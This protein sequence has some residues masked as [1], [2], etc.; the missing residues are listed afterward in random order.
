M[1]IKKKLTG[2]T[3]LEIMITII[4]TSMIMMALYGVLVSA[5]QAHELISEV[6]H[7]MDVG[8]LIMA[9]IRQDLE[10]VFVPETVPPKNFSTFFAGVD[11]PQFG[12][13]MDQIG[14]ITT[15]PTFVFEEGEE[16]PKLISITEVGYKILK[17][18]KSQN[19]KYYTLFRR[20]EPFIGN[21][22]SAKPNADV[23]T[24]GKLYPLYDKILSFKLEFLDPKASKEQQWVPA[25]QANTT[26][27]LP[28]AVKIE[29]ILV[30]LQ[31]KK[32]ENSGSE[33]EEEK[34][35]YTTIITL[36]K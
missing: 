3:L 29:I 21:T 10:A 30:L 19:S 12:I 8:P 11:K 26:Q 27:A 15:V 24:G 17:D 23:L 31:E 6:T 14:F 28:D 35:I 1:K 5:L 33:S 20:E 7:G 16:K 22:Q 13:E 25:W 9:Q 4:I 18:P 32:D 36:P 34:K 2:F